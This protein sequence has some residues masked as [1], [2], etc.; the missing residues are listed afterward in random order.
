MLR[1]PHSKRAQCLAYTLVYGE[2]QTYDEE[3]S[4]RVH[5]T[6]C[7]YC[8]RR[9]PSALSWSR[10]ITMKPDCRAQHLGALVEKRQRRRERECK[11]PGP[12][13][14]PWPSNSQAG[15]SMQGADGAEFQ[16]NDPRRWD[17]NG[18]TCGDPYIKDFPVSTAGK[19]ISHHRTYP[20]SL[21]KYMESC[22]NLAN[23]RNMEAAE[24]LMT[25]GLSG[26]DRT[27]HLQSSFISIWL[28]SG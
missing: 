20:T 17:D 24:L 15:P 18:R 13:S 28:E 11:I 27:R 6:T 23:L 5:N 9:L 3:D 26:R 19:P 16:Y 12:S 2:I 10:H 22:G 8:E 21:S 7:P 14:K 25:T 1:I 4:D